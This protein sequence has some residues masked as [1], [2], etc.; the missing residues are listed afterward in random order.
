MAQKPMLEGVRILAVEQYGA[1]PFGTMYLADL[2]AEVIAVENP[3]VKGSARIKS[4][5]VDGEAPLALL[6]NLLRGAGR[7][8]PGAPRARTRRR[9]RLGPR[10]RGFRTRG[11]RAAASGTDHLNHAPGSRTPLRKERT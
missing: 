11:N 9:H 7:P 3:R 4:I 6:T 2:G 10:R 1:G 5:P 8:P